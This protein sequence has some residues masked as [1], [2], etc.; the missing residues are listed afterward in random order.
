M[1]TQQIQ[2]NRRWMAAL[3]LVGLILALAAGLAWAGAEASNS[4]V[5]SAHMA[6]DC[7]DSPQPGQTEPSAEVVCPQADFG[8]DESKSW[9]W[10]YLRAIKGG[11]AGGVVGS[12]Q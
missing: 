9:P 7:A 2:F 8:E 12:N 10:S 6:Q 5:Q 3:L 11:K 1:K 4:T